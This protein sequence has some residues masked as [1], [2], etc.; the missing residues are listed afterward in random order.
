MTRD[1]EGHEQRPQQNRVGQRIRNLVVALPIGVKGGERSPQT[2]PGSLLQVVRD[3][4]VEA[5]RLMPGLASACPGLT[6]LADAA[7]AVA[8]ASCPRPGARSP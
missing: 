4:F 6:R 3:R 1:A 5:L 2:L 7:P 8:I